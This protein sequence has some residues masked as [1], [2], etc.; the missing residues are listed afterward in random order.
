MDLARRAT[1]NDLPFAFSVVLISI[2][3]LQGGRSGL[4][5]RKLSDEKAFVLQIPADLRREASSPE[6]SQDCLN[7]QD[8]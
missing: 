8:W 7:A 2:S 1:I 3:F 5:V 6:S 4:L